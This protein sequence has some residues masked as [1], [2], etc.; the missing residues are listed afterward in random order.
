[1]PTKLTAS[2]SPQKPDQSKAWHDTCV[3]AAP[4]V[5][6][7]ASLRLPKHRPTLQ[8]AYLHEPHNGKSKKPIVGHVRS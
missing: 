8:V 7:A 4:T 2:Y 1:M 3:R 5:P 6:E